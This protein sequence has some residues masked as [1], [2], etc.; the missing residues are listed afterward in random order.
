MS[1]NQRLY[2]FDFCG[3]IYDSNTTLDFLR[4]LNNKNLFLYKI[5]FW[6]L[7]ILAKAL[8]D[9][10]VITEHTYTKIRVY[11]LKGYKK[12][13]IDKFAKEFLLDLEQKEK[14]N[15][16]IYRQL[17]KMYR[18][19]GRV[20]LISFTIQNI[21]DQFLEIKKIDIEAYG[22]NLAFDSMKKLTG[23][24]ELFLPTFGKVNFLRKK[25]NG[26]LLEDAFFITDDEIADKDLIEV[27]REYIIIESC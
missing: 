23:T 20:I 16:K 26:N 10:R 24:Y 19:G 12:N 22:S 7:W 5:K 27:V 11:S 21:L 25:I 18:S 15:S 14:L 9:F 4:F 8:K 13:T 3:T 17:E 1:E 2:L 6:C